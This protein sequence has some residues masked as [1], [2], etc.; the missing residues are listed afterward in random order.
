MYLYFSPIG[1]HF[2]LN[3]TLNWSPLTLPYTLRPNWKLTSLRSI[4]GKNNQLMRDISGFYWLIL[5]QSQIYC[6]SI[7]RSGRGPQ[8]S[9]GDM[10]FPGTIGAHEWPAVDCFEKSGPI[11]KGAIDSPFL[12]RLATSYTVPITTIAIATNSSPHPIT[13]KI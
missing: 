8:V 13:Y 9:V 4:G 3:L 10:I 7:G 6:R 1:R 12:T 5:K 2:V 11:L